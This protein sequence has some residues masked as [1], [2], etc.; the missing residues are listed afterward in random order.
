MCDWNSSKRKTTL[1]GLDGFRLLL[2]FDSDFSVSRQGAANIK[3][4]LAGSAISA[5]VLF[6]FEPFIL[7]TT[8]ISRSVPVTLILRL[9]ISAARRTTLEA[10]GDVQPHRRHNS[11]V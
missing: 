2:P 7:A 8:S 10:F 1:A 11:T 6:P 5:P 4:F 3:S 9:A